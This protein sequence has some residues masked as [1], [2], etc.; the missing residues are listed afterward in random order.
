LV[1]KNINGI[2]GSLL[3]GWKIS[4][5]LVSRF[6]I[7]H[8]LLEAPQK[9]N[10][11]TTA[12]SDP[13]LYDREDD[14]K[15]NQ[16]FRPGFATNIQKTKIAPNGSRELRLHHTEEEIFSRLDGILIMAAATSMMSMNDNF[17]VD[18]DYDDSSVISFQLSIFLET[19][20]VEVATTLDLLQCEPLMA[21]DFQV[22]VDIRGNIFH[23]DFDRIL[24][25]F[26]GLR[27]YNQTKFDK[28]V[29][30]KLIA[31]SKLLQTINKWI[32]IQRTQHQYEQQGQKRSLSDFSTKN[33]Y[34]ID[35]NKTN[36]DDYDNNNYYNINVFN[37]NRDWGKE[38]SIILDAKNLSCLAIERVAMARHSTTM[39]MSSRDH[40]SSSTVITNGS[41]KK[42][43]RLRH[44]LLV[45]LL[46]RVIM[47]GYYGND[48]FWDCNAY[49]DRI[50]SYT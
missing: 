16:K 46:Q 11:T 48:S 5:Y 26:G 44:P 35:P 47:N 12:L 18:E 33:N 7:K 14:Q 37:C 39:S 4:Q 43:T 27:G 34:T 20:S 13:N 40:N 23:L 30:S 17:N 45:A 1:S 10:I 15:N 2:S 50:H 41:G 21:L 42:E 31:S 32:T 28:K 29:W 19:L 3:D 8:F 38:E 24:S 9:V 25:Q 49:G 6:G 22:F 36:N